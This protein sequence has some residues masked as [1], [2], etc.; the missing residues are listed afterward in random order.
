[1]TRDLPLN[2]LSVTFFLGVFQVAVS[3]FP[4]KPIFATISQVR[5][6]IYIHGIEQ[7]TLKKCAQV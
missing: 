5:A 2:L 7:R 1:M 6:S 4:L 3:S